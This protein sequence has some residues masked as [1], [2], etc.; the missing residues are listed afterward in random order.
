MGE[1]GVASCCALLFALTASVV[2]LASPP[3]PIF[4]ETFPYT[5]AEQI[6]EKWLISG[7]LA[8]ELRAVRVGVAQDP[9]G[10]TVGRITVQEGDAL[11]GLLLLIV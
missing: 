6:Q 11:D 9:S 3:E 8:P 1:R 5:S 7:L 10:H 4:V 2:A